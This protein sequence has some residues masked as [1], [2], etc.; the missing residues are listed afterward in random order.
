MLTIIQRDLEYDPA[1]Y[2]RDRGDDWDARS[3]S[4]TNLIGPSKSEY[5]LSPA[6]STAKIDG[7]DRY[8]AKGQPDIEMTRLDVDEV[9]L[10]TS[11]QGYFDSM[12]SRSNVTLPH[13]SPYATPVAESPQVPPVPAMPIE[14]EA[15]RISQTVM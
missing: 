2:R 6:S 7:Y 1:L 5:S 3:V 14:H 15:N 11:Q 12:A 10:L 9:P 8:L 4:S 13:Y